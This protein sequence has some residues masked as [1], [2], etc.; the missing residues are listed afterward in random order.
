MTVEED[1]DTRA[2]ANQEHARHDPWHGSILPD[3]LA[4]VNEN[5]ITT[6][7]PVVCSRMSV[8]QHRPIC[9]RTGGFSGH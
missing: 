8:P 7:T 6:T 5:F 3:F 1:K 2:D 9:L 4:E